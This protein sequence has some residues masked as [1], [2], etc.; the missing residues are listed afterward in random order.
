[1]PPLII[2]GLVLAAAQIGQGVAQKSKAAKIAAG[3]KRPDYEIPN[4]VIENQKLLESLAQ[5]GLTAGAKQAYTNAN[6]RSLTSSIEA[7]LKSGGSPNLIGEAYDS[8]TQATSR[9]ALAEDEARIR[10]INMYIQGQNMLADETSKKWAINKFAP[11]ADKAQQAAQLSSQGSDN[12]WKG[13]NTGFS[14]YASG[15]NAK[16]KPT[17]G[18]GG[19]GFNDGTV[20]NTHMDT[21]V[22]IIPAN[23]TSTTMFTTNNLNNNFSQRSMNNM[24]NLGVMPTSPSNQLSFNPNLF[25]E[26]NP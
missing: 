12:I 5:Q 10:N 20:M 8:S 3:N 4:Q 26:L 21:P 9:M 18:L 22:E 14:A 2:A 23:R 24:S 1:M 6:D 17:A 25:S 7:I 16:S 11:Y 15:V 13:I 19:T